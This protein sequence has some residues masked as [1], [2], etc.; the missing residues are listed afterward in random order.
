MKYTSLTTWF[1]LEG[2]HEYREGEQYPFDGAE[3]SAERI[4]ALSTSQ[5][6]TGFPLIVAVDEKEPTKKTE[7]RKNGK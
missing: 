3:V 7:S 5:N 1:D 4:E 2:G 6:N